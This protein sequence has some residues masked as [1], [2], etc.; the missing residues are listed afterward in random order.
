MVHRFIASALAIILLSGCTPPFNQIACLPS[1]DALLIL[2]DIA[3]GAGVS[4]LKTST[5]TP[6]KTAVTYT[7][8]G[9]KG[10]AD[11]YQSGTPLAGIV[12]TPGASTSGKDDDRLVAFANSFARSGFAVIVPDL[13]NVRQLKVSPDDAR[14]IAD[15]FVYASG[16]PDLSPGGRLGMGAFSYALGP[17]ILGALEP[18]VRDKAR[19]ILGVGGYHDLLKVITYF[20]TGAYRERP[21]QPWKFIT[22]NSYGKWAFVYSNLDRF[23]GD[24]AQDK[25]TLTAMADRRIVNGSANIDDLVAKLTSAP[26]KALYALLSNTDPDK[27]P[28]L[29]AGLPAGVQSDL[30]RLNLSNKD[31]TTLKARLILFHGY[32]DDLVPYTESISLS[33]ATGK[34]NRLFLVNGL[35][36]VDYKQPGFFDAWSFGC[37]IQDVLDEKW[38]QQSD[39]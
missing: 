35:V 7:V 21:D 37:A 32:E 13:P 27:V 24:A 18:D 34:R 20:T 15:A 38:K 16:R 31:L 30:D 26:G 25:Q 23:T 29:V 39:F 2:D 3:A 17:T 12:L 6:V 19:F 1:H 14:A 28:A 36:H 10:G 8:A 4:K 11:L 5:P 9:R 33:Q 22:P